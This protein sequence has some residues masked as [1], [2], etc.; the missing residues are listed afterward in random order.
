MEIQTEEQL[1]PQEELKRMQALYATFAQN[2]IGSQVLADLKRRFHYHSTTVKTD[3]IDANEL[4]YA[5]GQR[6]VVL[7]LIQMGEIGKLADK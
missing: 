5:E 4:A 1:D 6:S 7:F 2:A 3:V